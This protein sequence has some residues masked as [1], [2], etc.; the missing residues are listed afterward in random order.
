VA[1]RRGLWGNRDYVGWLAGD[2]LSTLG[3][4]LSYFAFPL[5]ILFS[6]HS[7]AKTGIV[8]AAANIGSL[9]TL[10]IGG[11]LADRY[12]RRVLLIAGPL[13]QAAAVGSVAVAVL[14]GHVVLLHVA[15]AGFVDGTMVGVTT[16][17]SGAALRRLVPEESYAG[18]LAQLHA[19]EMGV[20]VAG[21]PLGGVLFAAARSVPFIV[22]ALSYFASIAG[23]LAI[24]RPLGPDAATLAKREPLRQAVASGLRFLFA[25]PY[26]RFVAWWAAMMNMLGSGLNLL[27][28]LL[29]RGH[30]GSPS[31]IGTAAAIG[32][33]GGIVGAFGSGWVIRR[34]GGRWLVIGLSWAIAAAAFGMAVVP[35]SLGIGAMMAI[36]S[37][38]AVPLNIVLATYEMTIIPD[39][40]MGR[41]STTLD[42]AA[43][44]LRWAAP[45][46]IGLVVESTSATTCAV[47]WGIAFVV[48]AVSV[49]FNRSLRVLDQPIDR[50][51]P[52]PAPSGPA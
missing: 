27:M 33:A 44:G 46:V 40:L 20:R 6:T 47:I 48:I 41:V 29:V 49:M 28:I 42:L 12:S 25:N 37:V 32:A 22:D 14:A 38:V 45:L 16:G 35:W 31:L 11:A 4:S 43:N 23:V 1:E 19:R 5:L 30:G 10:L 26:L 2:T 34:L 52:V 51:K 36:V 15:V 21:P 50:I 24:R 17:A 18:A 7:P 9:V 39:E 3:T 13:V 8:A